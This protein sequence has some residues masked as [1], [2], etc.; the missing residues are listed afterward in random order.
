MNP[1]KYESRQIWIPSKVN[2]AIFESRQSRMPPYLNPARLCNMYSTRISLEEL[3]LIIIK[4]L[5]DIKFDCV[6]SIYTGYTLWRNL[7]FVVHKKLT[8]CHPIL[9][10]SYWNWNK[11]KLHFVSFAKAKGAKMCTLPQC[12]KITVFV[13][14]D[15]FW[16]EFTFDG[17]FKNYVDMDI[18]F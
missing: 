2:S 9:T 11:K 14:K 16:V 13:P 12:A 5:S 15:S 1:A 10:L 4:H 17:V 8:Y 7:I 18:Q 6:K 3:K